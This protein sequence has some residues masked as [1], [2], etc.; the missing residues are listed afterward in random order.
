MTRVLLVAL[1]G[2]YRTG[3]FV[4]AAE[5]LQIELVVA[6]SGVRPLTQ[7]PG[8]GLRLEPGRTRAAL[9]AITRAHRQRPFVAILP[10]DDGSVE[11]ASIVARHLGL[12]GNSRGAV[13]ATCCKAAFRTACHDAGLPTPHFRLIDLTQPTLMQIV[14]VRFPCVA[15]PLRLSASRGVI[16]AEDSIGLNAALARIG[17]LLENEGGKDSTHVLVE[18][19]V[20]GCELAIEGLLH[21]GKL[22]ILALFEKPGAMA[23]PY[24][25][26][27]IYLTPPRFNPLWSRAIERQLAKTCQALGLREGPVHAECRISPT[28]IVFIEIANRT[29][30]G[31]CGRL[32]RFG[33]GYSLEELVLM[34]AV[35]QP[36]AVKLAV[37][38]AGVM[39]I[40]VPGQGILRRVEGIT[41][42]RRI[43]GIESVEVDVRRGQRLVPWPEGGAY[44][45]F[46]FA[47]GVTPD[48]VLQALQSAHTQLCFV[49][50]A[51]LPV[52]INSAT[53][54][55]SGALRRAS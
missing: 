45:G 13:Q 32:L 15:K 36:P 3:A 11:M 18:D 55:A 16:R 51:E 48:A 20:A 5:R 50:D 14:G 42:A 47:Q 39:M 23:G 28:G 12:P 4:E 24:F 52:A 46:I 49:I 26:E 17:K 44:P 2:S 8:G 37:G 9:A 35:G 22:R 41:A 1:D 25:E 27:N 6:A 7:G 38:A 29:V 19:F 53:Q 33:S 31:R 30:G 40:P 34:N 10:T 54:A 43:P 21:R